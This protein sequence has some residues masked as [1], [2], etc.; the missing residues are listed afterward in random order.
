MVPAVIN[1]SAVLEV[2]VHE[3]KSGTCLEIKESTKSKEWYLRHGIN[4]KSGARGRSLKIRKQ[5]IDRSRHYLTPPL[6]VHRPVSVVV[7]VYHSCKEVFGKERKGK[8]IIAII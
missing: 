2:G 4:A 3:E 5:T 6:I 1:Q 8:E 7:I